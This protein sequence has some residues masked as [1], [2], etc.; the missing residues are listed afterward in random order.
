MLYRILKKDLLRRKGVNVILFLF[1][2]IATIFLASSVNNILVVSSAIDYYTNY[3][4]IPSVN[5]IMRG[6]TESEK[7]EKWLDSQDGKITEY[8]KSS[9]I[10]LN[11][12]DIKIVRNQK[13]KE[14]DTAGTTVYISAVGMEYCKVFD[15]DGKAFS[16]RAGQAAMTRDAM[17]RNHLKTGD[18]IVVSVGDTE[19]E[20]TVSLQMKD[21]AFGNDMTGMNRII[22]S[23]QDY[24]ALHK[25]QHAEDINMYLVMTD[26]ETEFVRTLNDQDFTTV[27]S[28]VTK[29]TYDM[30]YSFDM[31]MAALLI[32]VGICLILIALLVLRF[33]LV[34]T[35]EE[36]YREIG[37]M[38]AVGF[39]NFIVKKVYLIKYLVLVSAGSVIGFAAS[40]PVSRFM[41]KSVSRNMIMEDSSSNLW[42][43]FV[44]SGCIV[45]LVMLF[46]YICTGKLDKISAIAAIR[47][48][49]SGERY[50][51]RAGIRLNRRGKMSV[52]MF[53]G[54]NDML[55]HMRR[56][57]VLMITFCISF[58]LI[59]IPLNTINTMRSRE[60]VVKFALDPESAVYVRRIEQP[61]EGN[62]KNKE[63]LTK[64]MRRVEQEMKEKGYDAELTGIPFY[65]LKISKDGTAADQKLLVLQNLGPDNDYLIYDKGEAPR[66]ENEIALSETVLE[67]N[68]WKIG[69]WVDIMIGS[70]NKKFIITGTY[71]DYMQLGQSGRLNPVIDM[72]DE[73]LADY[74]NIL[75]DM[76]TDK[77]QKELAEE[78]Q[79]KLP[80]YEWTDAQTLVDQNVGGIQ[81]SLSDLLLPMTGLLCAI[82][83][84]ITA[85]M[86]K[87]FIVRE[88]GEIAMMK[89][90]GF[91]NWSIRRWQILRMVW[92]VLVSMI[93]AV[94]LSLL[95]NRFV[96]KPIFAIMGASVEIQ[97]VPWQVY[98]VYPGILLV[99]IITATIFATRKVKQ[100]HIREMNN[101]E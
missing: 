97:V 56:Y 60:M 31:I 65:F 9:L 18:K 74:W 33:T 96:L 95:S 85:L 43:N 50:G 3:S 20:M 80:G 44:C 27:L 101:I 47:S 57:L 84:L 99:G 75:V 42:V 24:D 73:M 13:K 94:P 89:S 81:D 37:I 54:L 22:L 17:E 8:G 100:I 29:G 2:T 35:M 16:L 11:D 86:E 5:F 77:T 62:Y 49:K 61:S 30:I 70:K 59:T 19:K 23:R 1:I 45:F 46:C 25:D 64:G 4:K 58:V 90:V 32:L 48:G 28:T 51:R 78:L 83:M 98:G 53:L 21:A 67:Q 34:F 10:A 12:Q 68:E 38:K 72:K 55:T 36:E 52:S 7:A 93:A 82:I 88:K 79:E 15:M 87:L 63:E 40:V 92:V 76:D 41:V 39:R 71:S 6:E 91:R 69:D 26:D 66:L 14:Y